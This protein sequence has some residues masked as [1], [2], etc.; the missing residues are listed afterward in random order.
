MRTNAMTPKENIRAL[1]DRMPDDM[2][3]DQLFYKLE[4]FI[5]VFTGV[6]QSERGEGIDHDTLFDKLL[7]DDEEEKK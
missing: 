3:L 4:L 6:Q 5:S 7:R 1:V 2:T